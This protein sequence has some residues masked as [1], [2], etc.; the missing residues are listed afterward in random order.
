MATLAYDAANQMIAAIESAGVDDP[1]KV[2][3]ALENINWEGVSGT[4]TYDEHHNPIKAAV[5]LQVKDGEIVFVS[6][7][8]P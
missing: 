7:V 6:S 5:I 1:D 4:I 8:A 2:K 3:D